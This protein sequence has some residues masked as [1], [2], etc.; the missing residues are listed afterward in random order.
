MY[1][2]YA[3]FTCPKNDI[4]IPRVLI[5]KCYI[6]NKPIRN[7]RTKIA[8]YTACIKFG[9]FGLYGIIAEY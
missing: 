3:L 1:V 4:G 6:R 2:L 8:V 7:I 5:E 9:I